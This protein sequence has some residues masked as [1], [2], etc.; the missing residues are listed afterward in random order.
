MINIAN[1]GERE[2]YIKQLQ[3]WERAGECPLCPSGLETAGNQVLHILNNW[4]L[5]TNRFPYKNTDQHLL[6]LP[7]EHISTFDDVTGEDFKTIKQLTAWA[8]DHFSIKGGGLTMRFGDLNYS[9]ATVMHV[10]CHVIVPSLSP[11]TNLPYGINFSL[12]RK[13]A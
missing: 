10:H 7:R 11:E 6:I 13:D 8:I 12:G 4:Q 9:G 3:D 5:I 1:A 2:A